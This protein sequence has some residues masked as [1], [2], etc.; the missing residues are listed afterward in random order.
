MDNLEEDI[1]WYVEQSI[2]LPSGEI[3]KALVPQ[4][5]YCKSS[6]QKMEQQRI[7]NTTYTLIAGDSITIRELNSGKTTESVLNN[8]GTITANNTLIIDGVD[9]VNNITIGIKEEIPPVPV[10]VINDEYRKIL[11]GNNNNN[12]IYK[13]S[14][15]IAIAQ[16]VG[17]LSAGNTL[18]INSGENGV[19][20]NLSGL[21]TLN[22]YKKNINSPSPLEGEGTG[23]RGAY[24]TDN[25]STPNPYTPSPQGGRGDDAGTSSSSLYDNLLYINTGP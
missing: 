10:V 24:N 20:N 6:L 7:A 19:L 25:T 11:K 21:I 23:E 5:Y 2:E 16:S 1:I 8:S 17:T 3:Y 14:E 12:N 22:N 18:I 15:N 4:I 13:N 9:K